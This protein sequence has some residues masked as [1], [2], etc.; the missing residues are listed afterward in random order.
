MYNFMRH[1]RLDALVRCVLG[2]AAE[3]RLYPVYMLR[4][5]APDA[6]TG[7]VQ[8]VDWHQASFQVSEFPNFQVALRLW[9]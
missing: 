9:R 6:A 4:A 2:G 8:T 3:L 1:E 5:K 7:G